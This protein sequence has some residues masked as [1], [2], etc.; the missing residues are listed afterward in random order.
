M[1]SSAG[2]TLS[3]ANTA[4]ATKKATSKPKEFT[5]K[6]QRLEIRNVYSDS[7]VQEMAKIREVVVRYKYIALETEF[8]GVV[9]RPLGA[10]VG[11]KEK[12]YDTLRTN[13]DMLNIIQIGLT[14]CDENGNLAPGCP[15]WQFNFRFNLDEDIFAEDA[16][17]LLQ[18]AGIDF[19]AHSTRGIDT[20]VFAELLISSGLVLQPDV[21]WITFHS[22]YDFGYLLKMLTQEPLPRKENEFFRKLGKFFP[23]LYDEKH[24]MGSCESL[25]GGLNQLA[26]DLEVERIGRVHQA[27][28]NSLLCAQTFFKL[29]QT[30]FG[31]E[32]E[33]QNFTGILHGYNDTFQ[34]GGGAS[35]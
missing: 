5:Y 7:L 18:R 21:C 26:T 31:N 1:S 8:P 34:S 3:T 2:T 22:G 33:K 4:T 29:K 32:L 35:W 16:I 30:V 15:C 9:V 17:Q 27:G 28:S 24:M 20:Q 13:V 6:G 14:F 11:S 23:R 10:Y 25:A 19:A 12:E